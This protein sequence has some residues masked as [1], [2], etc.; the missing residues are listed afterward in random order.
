MRKKSFPVGTIVRF[1]K[2]SWCCHAGSLARIVVEDQP[3]SG[4]G[5]EFQKCDH[6]HPK[7]LHIG[8]FGSIYD[9]QI[10]EV[11]IEEIIQLK[12]AGEFTCDH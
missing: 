1:V 7:S 12:L 4:Y 6:I 9:Y 5:V 10:E 2:D 11:K 8:T 3:D